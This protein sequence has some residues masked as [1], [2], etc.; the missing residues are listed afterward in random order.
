MEMGAKLDGR[1]RQIDIY[2]SHPLREFA[3]TDEALRVR[4]ET[5]AASLTYKGP[6]IDEDTKSREELKVRV[7]DADAL[8]AI[9]DRLGFKE[10]GRVEKSRT[11]CSV[12]G[13]SVCLDSVSGLGDF[14]ELEFE[15]GDLDAGKKAMLSMMQELGLKENERRSY[16]E[17]LLDRKK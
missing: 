6:K 8:M 15:G 4:K 1:R 17:L 7:S 11:I 10:S 5:E 9:F 13:I 14:V 3:C 16:L 12:S 2:L